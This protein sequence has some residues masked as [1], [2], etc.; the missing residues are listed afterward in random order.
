MLVYNSTKRLLF[1]N[2]I[3]DNAKALVVLKIKLQL[4]VKLFTNIKSDIP[5]M[6]DNINFARK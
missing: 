6:Y 5:V 2:L 1:K 4:I 3:Y